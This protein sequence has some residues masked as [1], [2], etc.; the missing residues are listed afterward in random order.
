MGGC[1]LEEHITGPKNT[2]MEEMSRRQIRTEVSF[3]EGLGPEGVVA[4]Y[5]E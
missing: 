5:M 3:E 2:R 1:F 4:P